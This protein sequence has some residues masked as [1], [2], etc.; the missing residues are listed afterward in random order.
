MQ[1]LFLMQM[2]VSARGSYVTT[3]KK[4]VSPLVRVRRYRIVVVIIVGWVKRSNP[5]LYLCGHYY[6]WVSLLNP[7]YQLLNV[8]S[9]TTSK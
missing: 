1:Q 6:C 5:T 3:V 7:T 9:A 4:Y 2:D 8:E